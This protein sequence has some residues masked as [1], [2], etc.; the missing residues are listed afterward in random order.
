MLTLLLPPQLL[1]LKEPEHL[2]WMRAHP[3]ATDKENNDKQDG[4]QS[5]S[6]TK[7]QKDEDETAT[8]HDDEIPPTVPT[9]PQNT[10]QEQDQML[11]WKFKFNYVIGVLHTNYDAY[12]QQYGVGAAFVAA[13]ALAALSSLVVKAYCHRLVRLSVSVMVNV[14][15]VH[16]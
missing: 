12:M 14:F 15:G 16:L 3:K 11:G 5:S 8:S 9:L 13:P 1:F 6:E 10:Q 4:E 7:P 2:N